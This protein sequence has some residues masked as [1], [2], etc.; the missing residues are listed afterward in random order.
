LTRRTR[1]GAI[2]GARDTPW[3][4][5]RSR[6]GGPYREI[7]MKAGMAS[8]GK[9]RRAPHDLHPGIRKIMKAKRSVIAAAAALAI[10][11]AAPA[12]AALSRMGPIDKS[13]TVGGFPAW[14]QDGTG[15]T[16]EF[17]DLKSQ[18]EL[19]KGWCVLIPPGPVFPESF[20]NN[21]FNEHF[22]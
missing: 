1:S 19:D 3:L 4:F 14:F 5:S 8:S 17:C 15:I 16:M 22:Y 21:Y 20:P 11:A 9:A 6:G 12:H 13:P 2:R 10:V 18:A 7:P